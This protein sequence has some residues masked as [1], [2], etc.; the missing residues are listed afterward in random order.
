MQSRSAPAI[1]L[2]P[3]YGHRQARIESNHPP[4]SRR[5][6]RPVAL[7]EQNIVHLA[8]RELGAFQERLDHGRTEELRRCRREHAA[9]AANG[10]THRL[11]D[12]DV[13]HRSLHG[14]RPALGRLN[15]SCCDV[16]TVVFALQHRPV[17]LPGLVEEIVDQ[18]AEAGRVLDLGPVAALSEDVHLRVLQI[19]G[20]LA[21][22]A[23]RYDLVVPAMD[24]QR[25]VRQ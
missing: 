22:I 23:R 13:A 24:N 8:G 16:R 3:A 12:D 19:G 1:E 7:G 17:N 5:F 11:A 20:E 4:Q 14:L 10:G 21:R 2:Q 18:P 9:E 25:F 6:C 15:P